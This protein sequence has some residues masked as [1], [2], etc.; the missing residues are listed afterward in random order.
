[1]KARTNGRTDECGG[2]YRRSIVTRGGH[3]R[4]VVSHTR[5]TFN[6]PQPEM[7]TPRSLSPV[8]FS[9]L[10]S[11]TY[12]RIWSGGVRYVKSDRNF[13]HTAPAVAAN[14]FIRSPSSLSAPLLWSLS[15]S[16]SLSQPPLILLLRFAFSP[17]LFPSPSVR[18]CTHQV[19]YIGRY[20]SRHAEVMDSE[21]RRTPRAPC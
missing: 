10:T 15:L 7:K 17:P 11:R 2:L 1:M 6:K 21:T 12:V 14:P 8:F 3:D 18:R 16:L 20:F 9:Y 5:A 13:S 4:P 19:G